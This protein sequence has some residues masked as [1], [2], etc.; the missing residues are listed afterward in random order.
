MSQHDLNIANA[1]GATVR[2]DLNN[3]LV[4]L[5]ENSS[6]AAAPLTTFANMFWVD[7]TAGLLKMR[8][9]ANS[10]WITV[11]TLDVAN[12]ALQV[13]LAV[14]SRPEA[15]A[16]T[17]TT[18][19]VWTAQRVKQAI[20]ALKTGLQSV[21][22]FTTGGTWTKPAGIK[23]VVIEVTGG[24]GGGGGAKNANG[25]GGGGGGGGNSS[26]FIDVTAI[27]SETVTIGGGGAGGV[28]LATGAAGGTSSLG[29]HASA[30]GGRGG[31]SNAG[32]APAGGL[33]GAGSGGDI[34]S[35]GDGGGGGAATMGVPSGAGGGSARGGGARGHH[36]GN[37]NGYAATNYGGG[38]G[39]AVSTD[40]ANKTGGA[41]SGGAVIVWEYK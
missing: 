17:A 12:L 13:D 16:G 26:K 23:S 3:A 20:V 35:T 5:G 34:N 19:R 15:E 36:A 10:A 25:T 29:A 18:E 22:V 30:T 9:R 7:T 4:A 41:G 6:G 2:G 39:G 32:G 21:Q 28:G 27:A 40:T 37:T 31:V 1:D 11:G 14:P 33:G 8:N 38:G 24:G